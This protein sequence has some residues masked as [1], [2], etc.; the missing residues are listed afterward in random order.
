MTAYYLQKAFIEE[1]FEKFF[2]LLKTAFSKIPYTIIPKENTER[3][4]YYHTLFYLMMNLMSDNHFKVYPE[5]LGSDSRVDMMIDTNNKI[6]I[7]EFKCNQSA[8]E[9][10]NQIKQKKYAQQFRDRNKN[11]VLVGIDFDSAAKNLREWKM[12]EEG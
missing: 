4:L 6:Y 7:F 3:E 11:I 1:T 9:A 12:E 8:G 2:D 5:L 10:I